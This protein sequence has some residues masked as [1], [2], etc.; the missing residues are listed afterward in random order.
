MCE[1]IYLFVL[2]VSKFMT[3]SKRTKKKK[4][5][6]TLFDK[7]CLWATKN[8]T[9]FGTGK[10][11]DKPQRAKISVDLFLHRKIKQKRI[12]ETKDTKC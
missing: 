10:H 2:Y 12:E 5:K 6:Y 11:L 3:N 8:K 7:Q 1:Y 4:N 9:P